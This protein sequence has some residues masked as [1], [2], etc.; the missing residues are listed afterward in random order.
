MVSLLS[1]P[2][3]ISNLTDLVAL[4]TFAP[5]HDLQKLLTILP[6]PLHA[7]HVVSIL[8]MPACTDV[9]PDPLQRLQVSSLVP[10]GTPLPPQV[11]QIISV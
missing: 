3:I 9:T 4:L 7:P 6:D 8:N 10:G 11:L 2:A 5:L 1:I